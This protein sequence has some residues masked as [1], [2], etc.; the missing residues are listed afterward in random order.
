MADHIHAIDADGGLEFHRKVKF[1]PADTSTVTNYTTNLTSFFD[2]KKYDI[3]GNFGH[4]P[5][6][7]RNQINTH[8]DEARLHGTYSVENGSLVLDNSSANYSNGHNYL[9]FVNPTHNNYTDGNEAS[10]GMWV[11]FDIASDTHLLGYVKDYHTGIYAWGLTFSGGVLNMFMEGANN[12]TATNIQTFQVG[13]SQ[14][15]TTS[16]HYVYLGWK[17]GAWVMG[18]DNLIGSASNVYNWYT[19]FTNNNSFNDDLLHKL[20]IGDSIAATGV[21]GDYRQTQRYSFTGSIDEIALWKHCL[22]VEEVKDLYYEGTS[23][24]NITASQKTFEIKQE[25]S[26]LKVKSGSTTAM[27]IGDEGKLS[28]QKLQGSFNFPSS[29]VNIFRQLISARDIMSDDDESEGQVAAVQENINSFPTSFGGKSIT[30]SGS[31]MVLMKEFPYGCTLKGF[32]IV[33]CNRTSGVA[34]NVGIAHVA[35][36]YPSELKQAVELYSSGYTTNN[37]YYGST[38]GSPDSMDMP[39]LMICLNPGSSTVIIKG[40]WVEWEYQ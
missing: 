16:Y 8:H 33:S 18:M 11:K 35:I 32:K 9:E 19:T 27:E 26:A 23:R 30:Q 37:A 38:Q 13:T 3:I 1:N 17:S 15:D 21:S 36:I 5:G 12:R 10:I 14:I 25:S 20:R 31:E 6:I 22:E 28:I 7:V 39:V 24:H 2:F 29:T 34:Q 40:G 4:A